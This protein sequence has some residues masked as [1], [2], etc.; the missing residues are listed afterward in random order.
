MTTKVGYKCCGIAPK[1]SCM[2][3]VHR[4]KAQRIFLPS[5]MQHGTGT[6]R[7]RRLMLSAGVLVRVP[8]DLKRCGVTVAYSASATVARWIPVPCHG[9]LAGKG[10]NVYTN[11]TVH[12]L[13]RVA[14]D[15]EEAQI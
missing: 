13:K 1:R 4:A 14:D 11:T 9:T 8:S 3:H 5:S 7:A 10:L 2:H 15:G 12:F 6:S